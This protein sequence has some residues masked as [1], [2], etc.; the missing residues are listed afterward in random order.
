MFGVAAPQ[1]ATEGTA[2]IDLQIAG[3]WAARNNAAASGFAGPQVTGKAKLRNVRLTVRGVG[4]PVEIDSADMQLLADE[5]RVAN[6]SAEAA[7]AS[8]TGSLEM[9]RGCGTPGACEVHFILNADQIALNDMS[10]WASPYPKERPW[11]R[12]LEPRA[13]SGP[14]FL[15]SL[16]AS[17]K[18][19]ADLLKVQGVSAMRVSA[20]VKL[21]SGKL[22]ISDL[23]ADF[24]GG[25]HRGEW[26]ADFRV[27][28]ATCGGKGNMT[29]VS[30]ARLAE[31]MNDSWIAG[32]ANARY[33]V[34]GSCQPE[35]WKSADGTLQFDVR[36]GMLTHILL[37]D[38]VELIKVKHFAGLAR[39]Q[40]GEFELQGAELDS[41]EDKFQVSG[42]AS[43]GRQL[44][45]KLSRTKN[46]A[47]AVGYTITGTL[48]EPRVVPSAG[49]ETQAR[50]K[51]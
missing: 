36:D 48:A 47:A 14:S 20:S 19:S 29:G 23:D 6:L 45:L 42:T 18:L 8:W 50:L 2:Q 9:P 1:S 3:S 15:A 13:Q 34:K 26:I 40:S 24:L 31:S 38:R 30:L 11:Y 37:G 7:G 33:E 10:D 16:R 49:H 43:L 51:P 22:Q 21:D 25:K 46:G 32:A 12:I 44:D 4:G 5:V 27:K 35:F 28:P 41:Q 17:G 39:L